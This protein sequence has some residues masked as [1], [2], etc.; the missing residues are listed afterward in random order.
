MVSGAD[1]PQ[2]KSASL[3]IT[4]VSRRGLTINLMVRLHV[5]H[6]RNQLL[7]SAGSM[8][9]QI[10]ITSSS[11]PD[12]HTTIRSNGLL[13]RGRFMVIPFLKEWGKTGDA[14]SRV[15]LTGLT[16]SPTRGR[17]WSPGVGSEQHH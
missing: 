6:D 8:W 14:P 15:N 5:G 17:W 9:L 11:C 4:V 3:K 12:V 10:N 16:P 2:L 1:R 7:L 13:F